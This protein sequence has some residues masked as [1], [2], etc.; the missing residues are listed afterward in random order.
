MCVLFLNITLKPNVI[1]AIHVEFG[2]Y[3]VIIYQKILNK[4]LNRLEEKKAEFF[5]SFCL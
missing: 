3:F 5:T 2:K 4:S 1:D